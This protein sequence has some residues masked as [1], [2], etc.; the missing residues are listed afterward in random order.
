MRCC[1]LSFFPLLAISSIAAGQARV[2]ITE[3]MY[4]PNS[5]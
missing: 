1:L 2:L 4:N 3:V 5:E